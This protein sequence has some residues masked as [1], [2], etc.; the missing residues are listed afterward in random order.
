VNPSKLRYRIYIS[1]D[2]RKQ[3]LR[4]WIICDAFNNLIFDV[5][6]N[7]AMKFKSWDAVMKYRDKMIGLDYHPHIESI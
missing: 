4:D 7:R 3:Y 2:G 6:R 5:D 1:D